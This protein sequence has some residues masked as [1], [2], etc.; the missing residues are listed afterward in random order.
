M[1]R[2][3][4][5]ALTGA[6]ALTPLLANAATTVQYKPGVVE[7]QLAAGKTVFVDFYTDWCTTCRAQGRNIEALRLENPEYDKNI[8]FVKVDWDIYSRSDI[9][10]KYQI[11]RRSTLI[12]L[13]G[14]NEL[15]RNVADPRKESIKQ[16]MDIGLAA[17][18]S[19]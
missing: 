1:K 3:A 18:T 7:Q 11:P 9:A 16:L 13:K 5:L 2:R 12:V 17:A 19:A 10:K 8:V 6:A 14:K 4:F 15:G